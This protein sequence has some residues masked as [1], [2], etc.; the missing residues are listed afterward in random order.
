M[1]KITLAILAAAAL[2]VAALTA[3]AQGERQ[4]TPDQK[5]RLAAA[6]IEN[7]YVEE[8]N[9]DSVVSEAI[10]AMLKT[11]DP[12]SAYST[13][14]ETRELNQPLEG[15]F[16]GIGIQF[17]M[18]E[19]TLY[20]IQTTP[21]GPSERVGIRPGD[22]IISA[23][24]TVIAGRK[25]P[26]T[27]IIKVLRGPKGTRVD[28]KVKRGADILDFSLH[29]DDIPIYSVDAAYM[30]D[31]SVGFISVTRFA[32]STA[33]EVQRAADSLARV[34]MRHLVL[35][36][37]S[38]GGGYLGSA[39]ELASGFLRPGEPVVYTKGLH[40]EPVYFG[41]EKGKRLPVDRLVVIVDQYSA[42]ASEIL[43]GAVQ[44]NDRGLIVGR[45]TFG[46]GLVQRPF[47]F[48]D[49]SM[50]RLTTAR[51]YTPAGR[52]IQKPYEKGRGE[53]YQLD[54]LNRYNSGELWHADSIHLDRSVTYRTLRSGRPV[55]GGGGIMPD[56][57]VPAD[58]SRYSPYYR[59]L[60]AKG[61]MIKYTLG[62][63]DS[64]RKELLRKYPT[65]EAFAA[66]YTPTE[67]VISGLHAAGEEQ[68]VPLDSAQWER[69]RELIEAVL[70]GL[71]L[72][73]LYENGIYVRATNPLSSDY[74]TALD[75]IRDPRR[76][77]E[78]LERRE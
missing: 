61:V 66:G 41:A 24:D 65:E 6:L 78:L 52:C 7:Y 49:G 51:Y 44:D 42:S 69:S 72:R 60:M 23:N 63:I 13:P 12:H 73:D 34:G 75:L 11:L 56:V 4:L 32:E 3:A 2:L 43:S 18:V 16:S 5:L 47:P 29:R 14:D 1:K 37:S 10:I 64:H 50:I 74:R 62:Y 15:K 19:D 71:M 25:M 9:S 30:A 8:V 76:Y 26:N 27:E 57:F 39:V 48:P 17:N 77:R 54:M 46:K 67:D 40:S 36:L 38:N 20:V 35:D 68:G 22:R 45:R 58:T 33:R 31:D 59:D 21:G 53:E 55:Y 28:L 70:K